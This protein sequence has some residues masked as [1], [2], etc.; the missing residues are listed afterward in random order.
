MKNYLDLLKDVRENGIEKTDRTGTGTASV[1]GR[2]LRFD[3]REGFPLVTTK[4]VH[5][6]SI[7]HELLWFIKGETNI[8][9]LKENGVSIWDEWADERGELGPVY[10]YQWRSWPDGRGNHTD[11]LGEV[12]ETLKKNPDSR[13]MIVSAWNVAQLNEMALAPCHSFFQFYV[14][15]GRLSCG[16]YQ[17]SADLFLGV[18]FN[19]ASYA[20][21]TLM[22][23]QATGY[24]PGE[25]V[26]TF[27]DAHIYNNHFEQV[28]T[29]LQRQAGKL[30][31]MRL[32]PEV[33][34]LF[35][36][37]FEDFELLNYDP[38]PAIKAP[39]AV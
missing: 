12:L 26:H 7:I 17:R 8:R 10:G 28:E 32:N 19:I 14:A 29:Q 33:K 31:Q 25:F 39:V 20:L 30:P 34:N 2:Q 22:V 4:K 38:Q 1:F 35:D 21:L 3:L 36:F 27:G 9:Y 37:K 16:M 6:K 23:A 15:G 13:R 24:A 5:I 11:Q 18:P